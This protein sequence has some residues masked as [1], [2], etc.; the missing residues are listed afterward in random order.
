[1]CMVTLYP[2]VCLFSQLQI[3]V[4]FFSFFMGSVLVLV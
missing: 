2:S 1:M 4:V 3:S